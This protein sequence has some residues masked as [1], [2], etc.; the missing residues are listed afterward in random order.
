MNALDLDSVSEGFLA[1]SWAN[2]PPRDRARVLVGSSRTVWLSWL[3]HGGVTAQGVCQQ[4]AGSDKNVGSLFPPENSATATN[5]TP[6]YGKTLRIVR[7]LLS[8][9]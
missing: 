7:L 2:L 6:P 4:N 8:A 5:L 9:T 3:L 1:F